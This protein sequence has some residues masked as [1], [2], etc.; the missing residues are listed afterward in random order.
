MVNVRTNTVNKMR[1]T[2][3]ILAPSDK[4]R[5]DIGPALTQYAVIRLIHRV[6]KKESTVFLTSLTN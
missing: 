2:F 4:T 5:E 3:R 6:R 1:D